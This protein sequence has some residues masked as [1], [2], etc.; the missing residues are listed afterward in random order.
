MV[1]YTSAGS[2]AI[3]NSFGKR[4]VGRRDSGVGNGALKTDISSSVNFRTVAEGR[5]PSTNALP[6]RIIFSPIPGVL[7]FWKVSRTDAGKSSQVGI[8]ER[9]SIKASPRINSALRAAR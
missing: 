1:E 9:N 8:G 7:N 3:G 6:S 5:T 2:P 4:Q